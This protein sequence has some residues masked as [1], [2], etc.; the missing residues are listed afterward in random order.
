VIGCAVLEDTVI[1]GDGRRI[2][3]I[4]EL[5]IDVD[6][7]SVAYAIIA[8]DAGAHVNVPWS[9]LR[10]DAPSRRFILQRDEGLTR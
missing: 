9:A 2:G 7:G 1:D 4:E 5:L 6:A 3:T 8:R 10:F